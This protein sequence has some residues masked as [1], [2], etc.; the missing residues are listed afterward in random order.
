MFNKA[1]KNSKIAIVAG[2]L[3]MS[4]GAMAA[5]DIQFNIAMPEINAQTYVLMDYNS[6]AV[7]ASLNLDQRQYPASL[8]KMM[9]SY[10]VGQAIKQ[11]KIHNTDMVTI[12]ESSWGHK[13]PGSS[14]MFLNLNQQV[15]V[16]DLHRGIIIVSG[17]D[18]C[19]AMAEH[20]S[21][22]V[23]NFVDTM[24]KYVEQFGLKNT[25]FT[26]VH[27]LDEDN[28]YSSARDMAIIGARI[29]RDLPEEYKIYAEKDF[30]FNKIKQP[31]RNGLLWDK[32]I[33]VDGMKTGHTDK[34][35][36]NLVASAVS[37]NNMRLISV[38]MG[39]PTYKGREVESKKLLQ[40]GFANFETFKTFDSGKSI[41]EQ[42]VYYGDESNIQLGVLQDAFITIPKGKSAELKARYEL[43]K[44]YLEAPL[45]KGQVVGKVVYQLDGKDIAG[46]NLQ[47]MQEVKEGGIFGKIWDWLVLTIKSLFD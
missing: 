43:E 10:V 32:T 14:K 11:S 36:Y 18:A 19:V 15:S 17:N 37:P 28:Q 34:A 44:K 25:H 8:T 27:G 12:G 45:A 2:A 3:A 13:F 46:V 33:N 20:V 16:A 39:V 30:T 47:V 41:S 23:M 26:T 6:G 40:W 24:N 31:N 4:L 29:I 7:L 9:T 5:E 38:V 1:V 22:T 42:R 35:G 21:G